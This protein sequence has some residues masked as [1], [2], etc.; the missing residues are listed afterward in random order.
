MKLSRDNIKKTGT[1][2]KHIYIPIYQHYKVLLA[3]VQITE[4]QI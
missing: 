3:K 4:T 2:S 1:F